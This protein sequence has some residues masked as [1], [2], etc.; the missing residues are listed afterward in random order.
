MNAA[1]TE[2]GEATKIVTLVCVSLLIWQIYQIHSKEQLP[3]AS[4]AV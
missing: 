1:F 3:F 2:F 4:Y